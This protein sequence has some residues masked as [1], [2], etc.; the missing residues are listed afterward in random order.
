MKGF[1]KKKEEKGWTHDLKMGCL[2]PLLM[3]LL[4]LKA[5][6]L[7]D[8]II[9][10]IIVFF[11]PSAIYVFLG[12]QVV[13]VL[14]AMFYSQKNKGWE[15]AREEKVAKLKE[16]LAIEPTPLNMTKEGMEDA[17]EVLRRAKGRDIVVDVSR[18]DEKRSLTMK[19]STAE[20]NWLIS[21]QMEGYESLFEGVEMERWDV[22]SEVAILLGE[23]GEEPQGWSAECPSLDNYVSEM[24]MYVRM[25][26][27]GLIKRDEIIRE[28]CNQYFD[29]EAYNK[30]L[31]FHDW[32]V[33][34]R[35]W[36]PSYI[37]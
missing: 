29:R 30:G 31:T 14:A 26:A 12:C 37:K 36:F 20:I 28:R 18:D 27:S 11:F 33:R 9:F 34:Y 10:F 22:E 24:A 3:P 7:A 6:T 8:I 32:V 21:R 4:S 35:Y 19:L 13:L 15:A 17:R 1:D 23:Q 16:M 5:L 2:G 25:L